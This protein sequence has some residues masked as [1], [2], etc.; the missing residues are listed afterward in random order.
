MTTRTVFVGSIV[1]PCDWLVSSGL[2]EE[3][4]EYDGQRTCESTYAMVVDAMVCVYDQ[5]LWRAAREVEAL[6]GAVVAPGI[7]AEPEEHT[8][9]AGGGLVRP[10]ARLVLVVAFG[11]V[12]FKCDWGHMLRIGLGRWSIEVSLFESVALEGE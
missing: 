10:G 2:G 3:G 7:V 9:F 6:G 11:L 1:T 12:W 8:V 4:S 5:L